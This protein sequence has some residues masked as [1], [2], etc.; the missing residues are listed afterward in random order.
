MPTAQARSR[1]NGIDGWKRP[2]TESQDATRPAKDSLEQ[3]GPG[4]WSVY[5][6]A[7]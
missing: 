5:L 6:R 4:T 2:A 1:S 7:L 3:R